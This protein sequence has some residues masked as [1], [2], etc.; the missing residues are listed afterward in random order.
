MAN[1][2]PVRFGGWPLAIILGLPP[3]V[4]LGIGIARA[5]RGL[6]SV[7]S[8]FGSAARRFRQQIESAENPAAIATAV[9][10]LVSRR[11]R[12]RGAAK[13]AEIAVGALRSAGQ[14][15]LAIQCERLLAV[16]G[17]GAESRAFGNGRSLDDLKREAL[18][19]CDEWQSA[20]SRRRPKPNACQAPVVKRTATSESRTA[21]SATVAVLAVVGAL[22]F[23]GPRA[24]AAVVP[25]NSLPAKAA[26]GNETEGA[27]P[28]TGQANIK[29]TNQQQRDL[30]AEAND[31]YNAAL[32]KVT[33]DPAEA[34][35]A[36]VDATEKYQVLVDAG[37]RN[38]RLYF[39]LANAYLESGQTGRAI[40]NYR[41]H[42]E[43]IRR[44]ARPGQI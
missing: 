14:R 39:D 8:R 5:R 27:E 4:V 18:A 3:L 19:W 31:C 41:A 44:L 10:G 6:S 20:N 22:A 11:C 26:P 2:S 36:F 1:Q 15:N 38:S 24:S 30:L 16:C 7:A 13:N 25:A 21:V 37:I 28:S 33:K 35:Q 32:A 17:C 42:C 40:A 9:M 29:L 34:K 43:S 12:V 23:F